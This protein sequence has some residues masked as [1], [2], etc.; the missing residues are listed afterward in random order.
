MKKEIKMFTEFYFDTNSNPALKEI[1][2]LYK[3]HEE[4]VK[5]L[6]TRRQFHKNKSLD[7]IIKTDESRVVTSLK[8]RIE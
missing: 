5:N 3:E 7:R 6:S 4:F 2:R 8:K 1:D